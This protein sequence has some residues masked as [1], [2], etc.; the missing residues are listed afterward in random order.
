MNDVFFVD[1]FE[2]VTDLL[3]NVNDLI[4]TKFSSLAFDILL[5]ISFTIL[6]EKVKMLFR[7]SRFVK[8]E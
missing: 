4:L 1:F 8:S 5:E 3:K 7:F 2:T 6:K